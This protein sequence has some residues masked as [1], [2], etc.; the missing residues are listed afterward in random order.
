MATA[1]D[2]K[3]PALKYK[4]IGRS[5]LILGMVEYFTYIKRLSP[6]LNTTW[7]V[8]DNN[9]EQV[10]VLWGV[11]DAVLC[12]TRNVDLNNPKQEEIMSDH[13][14]SNFLVEVLHSKVTVLHVLY[15]RNIRNLRGVNPFLCKIIC[16]RYLFCPEKRWSHRSQKSFVEK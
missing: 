9:H 16:D 12:G 3:Y 15:K 6:R 2:I 11:A 7:S 8:Y 4:S 14:M 1:G 5:Y 10:V 13:T